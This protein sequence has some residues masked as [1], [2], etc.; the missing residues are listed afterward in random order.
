MITTSQVQTCQAQIENNMDNNV[1]AKC[2]SS[3]FEPP[4][5]FVNYKHEDLV[6]PCMQ[7]TLAGQI[8][9]GSQS[10]TLSLQAVTIPPPS[11]NNSTGGPVIFNKGCIFLPT[12]LCAKVCIQIVETLL[13]RSYANPDT[14]SQASDCQ[15]MYLI[16]G[17]WICGNQ[18]YSVYLYLTVRMSGHWGE[19]SPSQKTS[20]DAG[21]GIL[22]SSDYLL[23]SYEP[24]STTSIADES[25]LQLK[26]E[27]KHSIIR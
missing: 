26:T 3:S 19:Y 2:A 27:K 7:S 23:S 16:A 17:L 22:S 9:I 25:P 21:C 18:T 1:C 8:A 20:L 10:V 4:L 15:Q 14:N 24:F 13:S 11:K 12:A 6:T 5:T